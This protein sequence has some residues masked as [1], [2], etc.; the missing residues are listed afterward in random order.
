MKT[1]DYTFSEEQNELLLNSVATRLDLNHRALEILT[2]T[3][4]MEEIKIENKKLHELSILL[5]HGNSVGDFLINGETEP[6]VET[7]LERQLSQEDFSVRTWSFLKRN[8]VYTLGD[9]LKYRKTDY[10]KWRMFGKK[11]LMEIVDY[12]ERFGY[13]LK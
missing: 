11:S 3:A 1:F 9:L 13:K 12:V 10:L 4:A 5:E 2:N 7:A 8:N 6:T